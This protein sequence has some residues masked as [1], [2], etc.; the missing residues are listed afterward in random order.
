VTA[1]A[2]PS[3]VL[4]L[5]CWRPLIARALFWPLALSLAGIACG[6]SLSLS[7]SAC[8]GVNLCPGWLPLC[9]VVGR[10]L[11]QVRQ[12]IHFQNLQVHAALYATSTMQSDRRGEPVPATLFRCAQLITVPFPLLPL[13]PS[14]RALSPVIVS[15]IQFS[16][17]CRRAPKYRGRP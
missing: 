15:S 4:E 5:R 11:T 14:Q 12:F 2:L 17:A 16:L 8:C 6:L 3:L 1:E 10:I 7:F 13:P 9:K